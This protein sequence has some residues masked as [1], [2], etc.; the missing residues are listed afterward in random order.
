MFNNKR[1]ISRQGLYLDLSWHCTV[2]YSIEMTIRNVHLL[3]HDI[4]RLCAKNRFCHYVV[5]CSRMIYRI[6]PHKYDI[7]GGIF[8]KFLQK[9]KK[10][11]NTFEHKF[12]ILH[13]SIVARQLMQALK[14]LV[15]PSISLKTGWNSSP[16]S[17]INN[18]INIF[19]SY[20]YEENGTCTIHFGFFILCSGCEKMYL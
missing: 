5:I 3:I 13:G 1:W 11:N 16:E 12:S 8:P 2:V 10:I 4:K 15:I 6:L 7:L 14:H 18:Y 19:Y 9:I 17:N 20:T